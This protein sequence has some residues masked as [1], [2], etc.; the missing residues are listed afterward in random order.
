MPKTAAQMA[1]KWGA[2]MKAPTTRQNYVDGINSTAVNPMEMAA[3][4]AATQLYLN[5]VQQSVASGRRQA[6]LRSASVADWK[7]NAVNV[8]A[9][10]L[11]TGATKAANKVQA[12][13]QKWSPIYEQARQAAAAIPKDG[14]IGGAMAKVQASLQVLMAAAGKA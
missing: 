1:A 4:E 12:H 3:S 9:N 6:A 10:S 13:F 7:N 5:K 11:S 2:A 14:T 8:G